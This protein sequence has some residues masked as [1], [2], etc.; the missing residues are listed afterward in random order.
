MTENELVVGTEYRKTN[1]IDESDKNQ[2]ATFIAVLRVE[3]G[4]DNSTMYGK[5]TF[6]P[7]ADIRSYKWVEFICNPDDE[8]EAI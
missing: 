2:G 6:D 3:Y 4:R 5:V 8:Y 7:N 1:R